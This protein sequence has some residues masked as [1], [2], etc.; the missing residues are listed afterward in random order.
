MVSITSTPSLA[1]ALRRSILDMQTQ[2][3]KAQTEVSTGRVADL[4]VSLGR[5]VTLDY[6][7]GIHDND[8]QALT[9]SNH[10]VSVRLDSTQSALTSIADTAQNFLETLAGAQ[11]GA[12]SDANGL[13]N[14]AAASLK[15]LIAGLNTNV[16]GAYIFG[17]INSDAAPIADYF[18]SPSS[19]NKQAVDLAFSSEFGMSQ[20]DSGVGSITASQMQAFL[21]GSFSDLFSSANWSS[22]WSSASDQALTNRV[23]LDQTIET[24][25]TANDPALQKLAMA[26][27]MV[28]DLGNANLSEAAYKEVVKTATETMS[29]AV[30]ELTRLQA[31][32]GG[33]QKSLTNANQVISVQ[34]NAIG[35]QIG[36]L[37]NV[38]PYEASTRVSNLLTQI[39]TSYTITGKI[40]QLTLSKYI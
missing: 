3:S 33:M 14:S 24:S 31:S 7:L 16:A 34:R 35:T 5:G 11:S 40:Q 36:A 10:V 25:V 15:S 28:A 39:Q 2:L 30:S 12:G 9:Q 26:Y 32:V 38:D 17:G 8:L 4:G 23:A 1:N 37:E 19:A 22:N 6:D 29:Q 21:S 27:T 13:A 18:A 20:S